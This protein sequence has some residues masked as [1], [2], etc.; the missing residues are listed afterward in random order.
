MKTWLKENWFKLGRI[1][2]TKVEIK[3]KNEHE[4]N[5]RRGADY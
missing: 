3:M 5:N 1:Q 4:K 2:H